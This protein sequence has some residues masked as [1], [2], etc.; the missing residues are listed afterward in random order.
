MEK[1]LT[2]EERVARGRKIKI[3][4][5]NLFAWGLMLFPMVLFVIF[6]VYINLNSFSMAFQSKTIDGSVKWVGFN[7]FKTF[8]SAISQEDGLL[9]VGLV[10]S[11][12]IYFINLLI[13]VPLYIF[14]SFILFKKMPGH[15]A[16]RA[17]VM[18]P[19]VISGMIV[20]LVFK[21]FVDNALPEIINSITGREDFPPL[22]STPRTTFGTTIFYMIWVSFGL[23]LLSYSNAMGE[24]DAEVID[25]AHIDGIDN[26]LLELWYI[27]LP[28]IY[29]TL[30]TF[31][32]VG[33][34]GILS[35]EGPLVTFYGAYAPSET[36]TVGYYYSSMIIRGMAS[37]YN[38]LAAGG[39]MMSLIV[40]PS[41]QLLK[42]FLDKFLP[43]V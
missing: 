12:K 15:N 28:L 25:S 40:V 38:M 36:Y 17:I 43:E 32:I 23:S 41:T 18:I 7:N 22:L 3:L 26:M 31:L 9:R 20:A 13:C 37:E 6:Y 21:K 14:F 5:E 27:I 24:I 39:F 10:N 30:E 11:L 2:I 8:I 33:F 1:E 4:K 16:M 42:K 35:N 19:N 29:P 34:T